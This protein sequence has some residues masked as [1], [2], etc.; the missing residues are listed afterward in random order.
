MNDEVNNGVERFGRFEIDFSR[1]TI[2]RVSDNAVLKVSRSETH[3]F[4]LLANSANQTIHRETLLKECW[5][6]KVVT[7]NSL[8]VAVKNL[9]TA[10]SKIGEHKIIQTEPKLGYSIK[11]S[12]LV[13]DGLFHSAPVE[14]ISKH[15]EAHEIAE[16]LEM[17]EHP[18]CIIE[19][20]INPKS[21][22]QSNS[23][24]KRFESFSITDFLVVSF[25]FLV[26]LFACYQYLFFVDTTNVDG[27]SVHYNGVAL[28]NPVTTAITEHKTG[29]IGQ[30]YAF[31][32]GGL[33]ERYKLIGVLNEHFIDVT[34]QVNQEQCHG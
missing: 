23:L 9:R 28:P 25:F 5:Q 17:R 2:T 4:A 12:T 32:V 10:F 26:T 3:I 20:Q 21:P 1:R 13:D 7:N 27:I 19:K 18:E 29:D 30:W 6:G 33:C 31:P 15:I 24:F 34:S 11:E 8:T 16:T 22:K 14:D